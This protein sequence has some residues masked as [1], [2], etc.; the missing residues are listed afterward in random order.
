MEEEA[1]ERNLGGIDI[2]LAI[3]CVVCLY[4]DAEMEINTKYGYT[5][6]IQSPYYPS[7]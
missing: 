2:H 1:R 5:T 4:L 7:Y 6:D 3:T